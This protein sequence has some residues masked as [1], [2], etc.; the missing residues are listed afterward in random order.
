M[1][2][3][4]VSISGD[5]ADSLAGLTETISD[6]RPVLAN[7]GEHML[8]STRERWDREISPSGIAWTPLR[9]STIASK[10]RTQ[11]GNKTKSGQ[12]RSRTR[13]P[14]TAIL[15]ESN[16]L[17]DTIAYQ[18]SGGNLRVGT[19]QAYGVFHQF[20]TRKMPAREFLGVGAEDEIEILEI[21]ESF[22]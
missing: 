11:K 10:S 21:V 18:V 16:L 13:A 5:F 12:A 20:G 14:A 22:L 7:I 9:P 19:P 8:R 17:R 3:I 15:R 4:N 2:N 1:T 6:L